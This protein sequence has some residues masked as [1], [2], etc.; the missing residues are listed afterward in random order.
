MIGDTRTG[1]YGANAKTV[2]ILKPL[3]CPYS[4]MP[5]AVTRSG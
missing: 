3:R 1:I 2:L 4:P 5:K